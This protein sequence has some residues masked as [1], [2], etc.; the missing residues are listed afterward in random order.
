MWQWLV[1]LRQGAAGTL[2][3]A[4]PSQI[5]W[6]NPHSARAKTVVSTA[7]AWAAQTQKALS[8]RNEPVSSVGTAFASTWSGHPETRPLRIG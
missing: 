6:A 5:V 3:I 1:Q 2:Q 8:L 7:V 4:N